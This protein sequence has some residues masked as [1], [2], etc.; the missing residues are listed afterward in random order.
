METWGL[1]LPYRL[2]K[3]F[4]K[5]SV[6]RKKYIERSSHLSYEKQIE[7]YSKFDIS[8]FG[9]THFCAVNVFCVVEQ[10]VGFGKSDW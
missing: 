3:V 7:S 4:C 2:C 10:C 5:M 9:N 1:P 8:R 6:Y